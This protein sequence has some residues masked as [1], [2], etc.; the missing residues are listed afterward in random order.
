MRAAVGRQE[1]SAT[2]NEGSEGGSAARGELRIGLRRTVLLLLLML[3]LLQL[4]L[5]VMVLWLCWGGKGYWLLGI[6]VAACA[7]HGRRGQRWIRVA[8]FMLLWRMGSLL[9]ESLWRRWLIGDVAADVAAAAAVVQHM[10]PTTTF[11]EAA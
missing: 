3:L 2:W 9:I 11:A 10:D 1:E 6:V 8:R 5:W 7:A 4:L